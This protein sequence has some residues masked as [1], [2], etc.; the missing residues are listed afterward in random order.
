MSVNVIPMGPMTP[1]KYAEQ[2][3]PRESRNAN[4]SGQGRDGKFMLG[5]GAHSGDLWVFRFRQL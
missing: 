4:I 3:K 1:V 2:E 5:G